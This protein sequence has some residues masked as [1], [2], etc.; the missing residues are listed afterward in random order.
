MNGAD[1]EKV[2][3]IIDRYEGQDGFLIQL[4][5]DL[6]S[7]FNWIPKDAVLHISRRFR[8]PRS[9]IYRI[10]SFYKAMSLI[11]SGRHV[12]QVCMGTA[13]QVR[14]AERILDLTESRLKIKQGQTT[15]DMAF[16]LK[17]VNCMG[18]CAMG[19]VMVVDKDHHG[20]VTSEGVDEILEN[21]H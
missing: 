15:A 16:S 10:A 12:I 21:Y 5:L 6:Q 11:P 1:L 20:G 14:G 17:R 19:P 3:G 8:I 13:C 9:R 18:C 2:N 7:E 4:L